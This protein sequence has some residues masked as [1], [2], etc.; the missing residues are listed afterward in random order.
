MNRGEI[1]RSREPS[2]ERGHKPGYYV[3]V[4][5]Q[6]VAD[7]DDLSTVVCAP[8]YTRLVGLDTEVPVGPDEG[9]EHG[10]AIRCDFPTLMF[11]DRLR[12]LVGSLRPSK[13][14]QLD[15]AL[16]IA[17]GLPLEPARRRRH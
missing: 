11:K 3:V 4:S 12:H 9:L 2:A 10:S 6:F 8:V 14:E 15:R 16:A 5:R 13:V 17:L 1:Y 7:N